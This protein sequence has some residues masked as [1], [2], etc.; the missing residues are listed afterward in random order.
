MKKSIVSII[1]TAFFVSALVAVAG[2]P[3]FTVRSPS[4]SRSTPITRPSATIYNRPASTAGGVKPFSSGGYSAT[5]KLAPSTSS[6]TP[7]TTYPTSNTSATV[8]SSGGYKQASST[9]TPSNSAPTAYAKGNRFDQ[10]MTKTLQQQ[11]SAASLAALKADKAKF[12]TAPAP[13]SSS[14]IKSNP[15]VSKTKVYSRV[16]YNTVVVH[17]N[18][19]YGGW[20]P[21]SYAYFG[22]PY[23]GSWDSTFL[24]W[25]L[26]HDTSFFY[27]HR[28]DPSITQ[29]QQDALKLSEQNGE[30]KAEMATLNAKMDEMKGK[31][32]QSDDKYLPAEVAKDPTIALSSEA[33]EAIPVEK[34]IIKIAT[35]IKGGSYSQIGEKMKRRL[36]SEITVELIPTSGA[37]ENFKLLNAGKADAAIVQSDTDFAMSKIGTSSNVDKAFHHATVYSEYVMLIVSSDSQIKSINDLS[38]ANTVYVGPE[39]SGTALTWTSLVSQ[40]QKYKSVPSQNTDYNSAFE[41]VRGD[42]KKALLFVAGTNTPL[43]NEASR[44]GQYRVVPVNDP[45]LS[46]VQD[47]NNHIIYDRLILPA[48][49]YPGMQHDEL[50]TLGVDAEWTISQEWID[51]MGEGAFDKVNYAVIDIVNDLHRVPDQISQQTE[52]S[53]QSSSPWIPWISLFLVVGAVLYWLIFKFQV[54]KGN[55]YSA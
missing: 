1:C 27:H 13:V 46:T 21:A 20:H 54:I 23:Y 37:E 50:E 18:S 5:T 31:N 38:E 45:S 30:L 8:P 52:T 47:K 4:I 48:G 11:Q 41:K 7:K 24:W 9:G 34:P 6:Y 33:I 49:T 42:N 2:K 3:S 29:W 28:S 15:V 40:N 32:I 44:K 10:G 14:T 16:E 36:S 26:I 22:S 39:G 51:K 17:R 53:A 55:T 43:L 19:F 12:K 35:G 25:A